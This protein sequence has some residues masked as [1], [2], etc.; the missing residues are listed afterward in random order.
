M[1]DHIAF[2]VRKQKVID[3]GILLAFVCL[4]HQVGRTLLEWVFSRQLT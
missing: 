3:A 2:T 1:V 4:Y